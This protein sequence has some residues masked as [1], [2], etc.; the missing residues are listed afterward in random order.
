M[1]SRERVLLALRHKEADR[2]AISDGPWG[3]TVE[4]WRKEGLPQ[5]KSPG[6]YFG[7]EFGGVGFDGSMRMT[8]ETIEETERYKIYT[9][10]DGAIRKSF[11]DHESTPELV[12]F[13]ITTR[14]K[15]NEHKERL[16]WDRSRVDWENGP[17]SCREQ[18]ERGLFVTISGVIGYD[19]VQAIL[20]S[21]NLLMA[22]VDDPEWVKEMF[23]TVADLF[24]AGLEEMIAGGFEFDGAFLYDDM[25]YRNATLFSPAAFRELSMPGH[26]RCYEAAHAHG[27]P[28]L[29]HSCGNV[30]AHIPALIE[31]GLDC[32]QPL[33]VKAGM[34]LI[35]LKKNYGEKLA[36]MGGIDVRA[37]ANP[38]PSVIEKEISTKIPVAKKGGGYIYHSDHSVPDNVSFQQ[39]CRVMDLVKQYGSYQ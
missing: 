12:G 14:E 13:T 16:A 25:G 26:R 32:L 38:D 5:D 27:L 4:R 8:G 9:T 11:K 28:T 33:E 34:D 6:E 22:M 36:F 24:V 2:V 3:T 35:E 15:W 7:Y 37:M 10:A 30:K 17:K 23:D 18:R 21:P 20:G 39:Y 1:T 29:L 19:R 31:A